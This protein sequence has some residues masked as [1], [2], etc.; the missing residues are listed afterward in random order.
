MT[1]TYVATR[2]RAWECMGVSRLTCP[3]SR[4]VSSSPTYLSFSL[5]FYLSSTTPFP[6][7]L[8]PPLLSLL[9]PHPPLYILPS[10]STHHRWSLP[11]HLT[12]WAGCTVA[13]S[14]PV[15]HPNSG[16]LRLRMDRGLSPHAKVLCVSFT[17]VLSC[18]LFSLSTQPSTCFL[19]LFLSPSFSH[20]NFSTSFSE[21]RI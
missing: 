4:A 2:G 12:R 16:L 1:V 10:S 9:S 6:A 15:L 17:C 3:E 11:S 7:F 8:P 5:P 19:H 18:S 21:T 20:R 14:F 13:V